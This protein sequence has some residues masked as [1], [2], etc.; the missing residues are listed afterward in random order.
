MKNLYLIRVKQEYIKY[1]K[2]FDS[3]VQD[4]S[5]E[6]KNKP[7]LGVLLQRGEQKY[8]VPLSSPKVK[9][10]KFI[11]LEI[12]NKLPIDIFLIKEMKNNK[13]IGILNINNMIPVIDE[14]IEY[15]NIKEDKDFSLLQKEYVYCIKQQQAI[16]K[17]ANIVY[18]LVT[19]HN[20]KS[21]IKR[22]CNFKLLEEKC[23]L[24]T[25]GDVYKWQES[26]GK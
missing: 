5:N 23:M 18:D 25:N 3:N 9:H 6:K 16:I 7:Y 13:L 15:F 24:Y 19:K 2:Q 21:L 14:V 11:D 4:N 22:S 8:F 1:L 10:N 20:K 12:Q 17:K 26:K